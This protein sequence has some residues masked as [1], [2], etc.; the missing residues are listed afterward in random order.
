MTPEAVQMG[1][2][3]Q[4]TRVRKWIALECTARLQ[5]RS[6][7]NNSDSNGTKNKCSETYTK[8]EACP[9]KWSP[10]SVQTKR[11][12]VDKAVRIDAA[13]RSNTNYLTRKLIVPDPDD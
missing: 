8:S 5:S 1:R 2:R 3:A 9:L 11:R 6:P 10:A 7:A 13:T 4:Q 12:V